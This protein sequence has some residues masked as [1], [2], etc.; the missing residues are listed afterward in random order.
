M[1]FYSLFFILSE[2]SSNNLILHP[3]FLHNI[4]RCDWSLFIND[5][6]IINCS[7][8]IIKIYQKYLQKIRFSIL[9]VFDTYSSEKNSKNEN[10]DRTSVADFFISASD[11]QPCGINIPYVTPQF[12][13]AHDFLLLLQNMPNYR[14]FS[15][16]SYCCFSIL[17]GLYGTTVVSCRVCCIYIARVIR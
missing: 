15:Y 7:S 8:S 16:S 4:R 3:L 1:Q 6:D 2:L 5:N 10:W 12:D 14:E 13:V 9:D 11:V 17:V